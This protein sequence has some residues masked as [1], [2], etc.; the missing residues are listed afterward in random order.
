MLSPTDGLYLAQVFEGGVLATG[1][2]GSGKSSTL[3]HLMAAM[4][5]RDFGM[6]IITAKGSDW[7]DIERIARWA[8]RERDLLRFCKE[9][10]WRFDFLQHELA[11]QGGSISTGSQLMQDLLN[12]AT[13]MKAENARDPFWPQSAARQMRMAMTAI[14]LATG[15]CS[16]SGI[17]RFVTSLPTSLALTKD[18][19]WKA[20]A[21]CLRILIAA[22]E[23]HPHRDDLD[24]AAEY[25]LSEFPAQG[26]KTAATITST[27]MNVLEKLLSGD[28][29]RLVSSGE[30]NIS[31]ADAID[32][33]IIVVDAPPLIYRDEG[34]LVG[35]CWKLSAMRTFQR[36]DLAVNSRPVC[37]WV[38]EAQLSA[39][40]SVD[41]MFAATCR[42]SCC[43]N[44][45][46]TQNINLLESVFGSKED[47]RAWI[48]NLQTKF[49]FANSDAET[50]AYFSHMFGESRQHLISV[51]PD[52]KPFDLVGHMLGEPQGVGMNLN[53]QFLPQVRPEEFLRLRKGGR[54]NNFVVDC[55]ITQ[56]GRVF[57]NGKT[58]LKTSFTQRV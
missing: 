11:S 44:V 57:S 35:A 22:E 25:V 58:W 1:A 32:G 55:F 19:K 31:P 10:P 43:A 38:D 56:G 21:Y 50:N 26:E 33:R 24:M 28:I 20:S 27:S 45:A 54:D 8:G 18:A 6:V 30:T 37:L 49:I 39:I 23:R 4:M 17:Y 34:T 5:R 13:R 47:A 3:A 46:I 7:S 9:K 52:N 53:E 36:R 2:T 48:S 40:P 41:S 14:L 42:S 12:I 16:V 51:S 15:T 29:G